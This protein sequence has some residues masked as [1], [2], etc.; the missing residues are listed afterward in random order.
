MLWDDPDST[1]A[2]RK[3]VLQSCDKYMNRKPPVE[4]KKEE[5]KPAEPEDETKPAEPGK[6][7]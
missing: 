3:A 7:S 1:E 5:A 6:A 2:F 4:Q